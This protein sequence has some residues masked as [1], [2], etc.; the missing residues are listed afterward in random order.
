MALLVTAVFCQNSWCAHW[1]NFFPYLVIRCHGS[2]FLKL[3]ICD[4]DN[5]NAKDKQVFCKW[6]TVKLML[7]GDWLH[8]VLKEDWSAQ[9]IRSSL[10]V[11]PL[12]SLTS[13]LREFEIQGNFQVSLSWSAHRNTY[14]TSNLAVSKICPCFTRGTL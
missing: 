12:I 3:A 8:S 9:Q 14:F 1:P 5:Q 7:W 11:L 2:A 6:V 10:V 4:I 13:E